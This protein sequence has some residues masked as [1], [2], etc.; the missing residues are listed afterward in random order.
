MAYTD[1]SLTCSDCGA[2]FYFTA[3]EQEF[4][5]QKGF[6][7]RPG[8]C[9]DCRAR[10]KASQGGSGGGGGSRSFG[11]FESG[12]RR[13][14]H[15]AVCASCNRETE[16]PFVPSSNRPVYCRD[17]FASQGGGGGGRRDNSRSRY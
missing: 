2:S 11:G 10:R 12:G 7:N 15:P 16:V 1:I 3:G 13:E 4:H 8:R 9:P 5:A 14:M 6:N 17:C